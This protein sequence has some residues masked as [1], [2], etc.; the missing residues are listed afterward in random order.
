[1]SHAE[2]C[3]VCKQSPETALYYQAWIF[4]DGRGLAARQDRIASRL[5]FWVDFLIPAF[6]ILILSVPALVLLLHGSY[7]S[8]ICFDKYPIAI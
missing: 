6:N 2:A 5:M 7:Q 4:K 8:D 1:M 3:D